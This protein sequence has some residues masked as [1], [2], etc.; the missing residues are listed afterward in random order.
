[1]VWTA[2]TVLALAITRRMEGDAPGARALLDESRPLYQKLG[3][4]FGLALTDLEGGHL[5]R[6]AGDVPTAAR[7]YAAALRNFAE[8]GANLGIVEALEW[9]AATAADQ[10]AAVPALRLFGAAESARRALELPSPAASDAPVLERQER[11]AAAAANLE[12]A[13]ATRG[14]A[15]AHPR[16]G[17]G[18]GARPGATP[19]VGTAGVPPT[20]SELR[21]AAGY[22]L[23]QR[24]CGLNA[25][26]SVVRSGL[27]EAV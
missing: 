10:G 7:L 25:Q 19:G 8:V 20:L 2:E 18:R 1:M 6:Q 24:A 11:C 9:L 13:A 23:R 5:A 16:A 26:A 27:V 21:D 15:G 4:P 22:G 3:D 12:A 14:R 17:S